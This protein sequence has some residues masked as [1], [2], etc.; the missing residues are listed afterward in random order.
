[1][2]RNSS[3]SCISYFLVLCSVWTFPPRWF[4]GFARY[5]MVGY[6]YKVNST[7]SEEIWLWLTSEWHTDTYCACTQKLLPAVQ[8][9]KRRPRTTAS[10]SFKPIIIS[11][12]QTGPGRP[13]T[14]N[15]LA[16]ELLW[17]TFNINTLCF[18]DK[19]IRG[20]ECLVHKTKLSLFLSFWIK[21]S[22]LH[23]A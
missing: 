4:P 18:S 5:P 6:I 17:A 8:L 1:M 19:F 13:G 11:H 15:Y 2:W 7:S 20:L 22:G 9:S 21:C 14:R 23:T 10:Q 12:L 16:V 3:E